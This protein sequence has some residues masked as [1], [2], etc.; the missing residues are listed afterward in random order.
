MNF[1]LYLSLQIIAIISELYAITIAIL[2]LN[3]TSFFIIYVR[4]SMVILVSLFLLLSEIYLFNFFK[5]FSFILTYW[6]KSLS[7][8]FLG[9]LLWS[10]DTL[11]LITSVVFWVLSTFYTIM[12]FIAK[13]GIANPIFDNTEIDLT[14]K[15]DSIFV[16]KNK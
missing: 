10:I 1:N 7:Y 13:D 2:N 5:Y 6:G 16:K 4:Q 14:L 8:L 3:S 11:N 15:K 9:S 12:Y